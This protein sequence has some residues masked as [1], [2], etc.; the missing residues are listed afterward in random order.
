[1][2]M[3]CLSTF[4]GI[5]YYDQNN[6]DTADISIRASVSSVDWCGLSVRKM[7]SPKNNSEI[8]PLFLSLYSE[9][10]LVAMLI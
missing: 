3:E 8:M 1:M 6:G 10:I 2:V 9:F 4:L 5:K 7:F